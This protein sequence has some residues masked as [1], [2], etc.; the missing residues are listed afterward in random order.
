MF[1]RKRAGVQRSVNFVT[2]GSCVRPRV[3]LLSS[4]FEL[5]RALGFRTG[6][7]FMVAGSTGGMVVTA[8]G[9]DTRWRRRLGSG[10]GV[11][12]LALTVAAG[13]GRT[14]RADPAGAIAQAIADP[15]YVNP[16]ADPAAWDRLTGATRD[17]VGIVVAN[18]NNGPDYR[19]V[20]SWS[21]VIQR[22][23]QA[24]IKVL[25][26]V[27][28]GYLGMTGL[29]TRLGSTS[30]VDWVSQM[31][32]DINAWYAFYG[33]NVDGIFFDDGEN[34]CGPAEGSM[35][36]AAT[37]RQVSSF[38][39]TIHPGA[40]T[41]INPGT[42]VPECY[43]T[44]ADILLTFE[45]SYSAYTGN[46]ATAAEAYVPLAWDPVDPRKIW[47]LVYGAPTPT[48]MATAIALSK[49]RHAGY[50][51]VT[52]DTLTN[53]WD[54][55]PASSYWANEQVQVQ[56][57]DWTGTSAPSPPT[58]MTL[59]AVTSTS[60]GLNWT[61]STASSAPVTAYEIYR[62]GIWTSSVNAHMTAF[63]ATGLDPSTGYVFAI[64]ARDAAGHESVPGA[65]VTA[66]TAPAPRS[67]PAPPG[68]LATGNTDYTSTTLSW[69]PAV[70][71]G[72]PV[73]GYDIYQDETKVM[74]VP[75]AITSLTIGGLAPGTPSV[76]FTVSAHD[77]SGGLSAPSAPVTASTLSLP[78][79][80]SIGSPQAFATSGAFNFRANFYMPFGFRRVFIQ[81]SG[82]S[83]SCWL[84]FSAPS[85]CA[86]FLVEN[87]RLFRHV[88]STGDWNWSLVT[89]TVP[90]VIGYTY[91][92]S[93]PASAIGSSTSTTVVF[94]GDGY[95]PPS[96]STPTTAELVTW[97]RFPGISPPD[98]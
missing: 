88:G 74:G 96:Y 56:R 47:H 38:V 69:S 93:V 95:A 1:E 49:S 23:H 57:S 51:Y 15:A 68:G 53:P 59:G 85:L 24:G 55:V 43:E 54:S 7:P 97:H 11:V 83:R 44:S 20:P 19:P 89:D 34:R 76:T 36:W 60:V 33:D 61:S 66:T 41:V 9:L 63:T 71:G 31:E 26:Y 3:L 86:D 32:R 80:Q 45:G 79:G 40:L 62:N 27:D 90:T 21:A 5:R 64:T 92:W 12:M 30:P 39:K 84:T 77:A 81:A 29:R 72:A 75:A 91:T 50:V 17:S 98:G 35:D 28:S 65:T 6:Y 70:P 10:M 14:V 87:T 82:G 18:V 94:Q 4:T 8:R 67:P 73:V 16:T 42:A 52:D 22:A 2:E 46:P 78:D 58:G 25:G 37:Y 48:E 13:Q